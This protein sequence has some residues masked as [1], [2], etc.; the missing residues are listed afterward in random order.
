MRIDNKVITAF[1]GRNKFNEFI[2][3][4]TLNFKRFALRFYSRDF[5]ELESNKF[6]LYF[7]KGRA[8]YLFDT[9]HFQ[10]IY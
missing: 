6:K 8:K 7:K 5:R 2:I 3:Y 9:K 1:L 10:L 4:F